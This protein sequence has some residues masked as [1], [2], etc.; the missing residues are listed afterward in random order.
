MNAARAMESDGGV[1]NDPVYGSDLLVR[2]LHKLGVQ[3]IALNPGATTRGLHESLV[4]AGNPEIVLTTHEGIAVAIAHGYQK[5]CGRPM[6]VALHNIVGLQ[7]ASMGLFN[8]W[9]DRVPMLVV[10]GSGPSAESRRRPWID[11]IHAARQ[12]ELVRDYVKWEHEPTELGAMLRTLVRGWQLA[13]SSPTG[14]VYVAVDTSLQ[15]D[16]ASLADQRMVE[17]WDLTRCTQVQ[18]S[19]SQAQLARIADS[20]VEADQPLILAWASVGGGP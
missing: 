5:A 11:W 12:G 13:L 16:G 4:A 14:P 3:H 9:C 6:A 15:E 18:A 7:H 8:A 10:G 2:V 19:A 17:N 1:A 20:L